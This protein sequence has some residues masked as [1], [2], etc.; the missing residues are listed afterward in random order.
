MPEESVMLVTGASRGIGRYLAQYYAAKE[1]RVVGCSRRPSDLVDEH[2]QHH[3]LDVT[4]EMK[5][6]ELFSSVR[7]TYG[8]LDVL[9]NN[10]GIALMNHVILTPTSAARKILD[11]NVLGPFLFCREAAKLMK[12]NRFGRIV[13]L[14]SVAVPLQL[15]GE[16]LYASSKAALATL[17]DILAR[18][19]S[20]FGITANLV[21]PSPLRTDLTKGVPGE[22]LERLISRQAIHRYCEMRDVSNVMD[23]FISRESDFVTGQVI[24]LGGV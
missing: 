24:Y 19:L 11:T 16:A 7:A 10:A 14:G 15:E 20:E 5:V 23:F 9:I 22:K 1:Y 13:N 3:C 6:K 8:R 18:E 4:D 21:A 12:K 2:Y 17:T